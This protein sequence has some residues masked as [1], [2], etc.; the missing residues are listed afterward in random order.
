M[1]AA[2]FEHTAARPSHTGKQHGVGPDPHLHTHVV[3]ANL[4]HRHDAQWRAVQPLDL[5]RSQ[6]FAT[7]V[8]R[9]ELARAAQ[10]LVLLC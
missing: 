4:T 7:A 2:Q 5:Y 1:V 10:S 3:I 9:S 8:Y 6:A